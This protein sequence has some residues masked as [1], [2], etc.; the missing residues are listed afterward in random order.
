MVVVLLLF[1]VKEVPAMDSRSNPK[2]ESISALS[3]LCNMLGPEIDPTLDQILAQ[4][5]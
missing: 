5:S 2:V 1:E 3:V 4:F